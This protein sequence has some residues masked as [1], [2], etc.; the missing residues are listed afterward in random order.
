MKKSI[1][2]FFFLFVFVAGAAWVLV[3]NPAF[4]T[5]AVMLQTS[6]QQKK[7]TI[8]H[9]LPVM[10]DIA[11]TEASRVAGLS[12]RASLADG[13]GLLMVFQEDDRS[14]IWMKDMRFSIDVIWADARGNIITVYPN[15]DPSSYPQVFYPDAPARYVLEVPAGFIELHNIAVGDTLQVE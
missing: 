14:G 4:L 15:M 5:D 13:H 7:I 11:D 2:I 3:A 12:G 10:V 8:R 1:V 9:S 6:L